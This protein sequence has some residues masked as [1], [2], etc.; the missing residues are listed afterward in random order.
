MR[1]SCREHQITS[2]YRAAI[3]DL[4]EPSL[5]RHDRAAQEPV[6]GP[7][8]VVLPA[9]PVDLAAE[10]IVDRQLRVIELRQ[11]MK[12]G[13]E[14]LDD[15]DERPGDPGM[16][17]NGL[18]VA[19]VNALGAAPEELDRR[20]TG[21]TERFALLQAS[22][23]I[24]VESKLRDKELTRSRFRLKF[25]VRHLQRRQKRVERPFEQFGGNGP[26]IVVTGFDR[27]DHD[28]NFVWPDRAAHGFLL[29]PSLS[30]P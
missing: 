23:L 8:G 16:A 17:N 25:A 14:R 15:A 9:Y 12:R 29:S 18:V 28:A 2:P 26:K 30:M 22:E 5:E 1:R 10:K 27:S 3:V 11:D 6:V 20:R 24:R 7:H 4:V 21:L 13:I 19:T